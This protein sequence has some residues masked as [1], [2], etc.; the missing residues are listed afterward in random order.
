[1]LNKPKDYTPTLEKVEGQKSYQNIFSDKIK[2]PISV[3]ENLEKNSLG[4]VL[5]TDDEILLE[6]QPQLNHIFHLILS[7]KWEE[8]SLEEFRKN[9]LLAFPNIHSIEYVK[10]KS[11]NELIVKTKGESDKTII[12]LLEKEDMLI[13]KIDR[14]AING[15]TKKDIPRGRYREL[16]PKEVIFIKHF[17]G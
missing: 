15:L 10:D 2:T 11:K 16:T 17:G 8:N 4:L 13:Q 12:E 3:L 9:A 14:V 7:E 1:M 5:F 6:K